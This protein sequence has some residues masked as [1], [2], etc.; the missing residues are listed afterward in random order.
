MDKI[1]KFRLKSQI[2]IK[3]SFFF[4]LQ[5]KKNISCIKVMPFYFIQPFL[6]LL[7]QFFVFVVKF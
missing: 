5:L 6:Y 7:S 3:T 1:E 2:Y 4:F